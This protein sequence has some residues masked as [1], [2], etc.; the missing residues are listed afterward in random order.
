MKFRYSLL[1]VT[2]F[3]LLSC[4]QEEVTVK[5]NPTPVIPVIPQG[6]VAGE[7]EGGPGTRGWTTEVVSQGML[8]HK[9]DGNDI[10]TGKRQSVR[11]LDID[12]NLGRYRVEFTLPSA[13]G[14]TGTDMA[15]EKGAVASVNAS[16]ET[17]SVYIKIN[18]KEY[19]NIANDKIGSTNVANW[20]NDGAIYMTEGGRV[21]LEYSGKNKTLAQQ[22]TYYRSHTCANIFSS[23]PMLIDNYE[24][25]GEFYVPTN[26]TEAQISSYNYEHP[27]NHQG[28]THPRTVY[29]TTDDNHLLLIA[30]DKDRQKGTVAGMN[31]KDATKF[32]KY[33]FNPQY[34][35]NMDGGG[36]TTI[37]VN[38]K[39]VN[40]P[41]ESTGE[42]AVAS[43]LLIHDNAKK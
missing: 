42:R 12:M 23:A 15:R 39:L 14:K 33:H 21:Y 43:Y 20:K 31:A 30:I 40:T 1:A 32:L 35:L 18:G 10:V 6:P 34:A 36:S 5:D 22:R 3:C 19:Y 28:V 38:G 41:S 29:A 4:G 7:A 25:V 2:F 17:G 11:V 9:F 16:Y 26:L 27:Y 13:S 37:S 24:Q 8:L